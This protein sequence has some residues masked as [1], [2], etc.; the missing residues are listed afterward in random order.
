MEIK[1]DKITAKDRNMVIKD[2]YEKFEKLTGVVSKRRKKS[3]EY[4]QFDV[5]NVLCKLFDVNYNHT[6]EYF[7]QNRRLKCIV[8]LV[9]SDHI[10]AYAVVYFKTFE[11][12]CI[13]SIDDIIIR[14]EDSLVELANGEI[15]MKK[16]IYYVIMNYIEDYLKSISNNDFT[17]NVD[18][19]DSKDLFKAL[20]NREYTFDESIDLDEAI[21]EGDLLMTK[22]CLV[23]RD[24]NELHRARTQR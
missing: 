16:N 6:L 7:N 4:L 9:S 11:N 17:I 15:N 12:G 1:V 22:E 19:I 10:I 24:E 20:K 13:Y 3:I 21:S 8:K 5:D 2:Y 18:L 14:N 23:L